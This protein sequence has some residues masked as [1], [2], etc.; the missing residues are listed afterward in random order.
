MSLIPLPLPLLVA[1][2][3]GDGSPDPHRA[4]QAYRYALLGMAAPALLGWAIGLATIVLLWQRKSSAY[5]DAAGPL[6]R[7]AGAS[8]P[9]PTA[10]LLRNLVLFQPV[11]LA[12]I[13][14][15]LTPA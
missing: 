13:T 5:F 9:I 2:A 1:W 12:M 15:V 3:P 8:D 4:S 10:T 7:N 11:P 6:H 14:H